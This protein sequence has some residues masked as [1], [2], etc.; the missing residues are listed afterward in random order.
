MRESEASLGDLT[1]WTSFIVMSE[2]VHVRAGDVAETSTRSCYRIVL[3]A[4]LV[5]LALQLPWISRPPFDAHP[6]RQAQTLATIELFA[7]EGIDIAHPKTNYVGEPGVFVLEL[8]LFQALCA[9]LY[10][11]FGQHVWLVRLVNLLFTLGNAG[12][13]FAIGKRLFNREAGF[14][15]MLIYLFAPL[16]LL[17]MTSTLID[18]S[19]TFCSLSAFLLALRILHA[20]SERRAGLVVWIGFALACAVTALIK[21]LYLFPTCVL[22][23]A[24]FL[25]RRKLSVS[26]LA[27]GLC[28]ILAAALFF[29][30]LRHSRHVND[31]SYFTKDINPTTLLGFE[32][33]GSFAFYKSMIRRFVLHVVGPGAAL[34]AVAGMIA[35]LRRGSTESSRFFPMAVLV[36]SIV[37][38]YLFFP[39]ANVPHDYYSLIVSPYGCLIAGFGALE[40][41]RRAGTS[42]IRWLAP[43]AKPPLVALTATAL[44]VAVFFKPTIVGGKPRLAP[45][46]SLQELEQLSQGRFDRWSFGMVF[47]A[48]DVGLPP[49]EIPF[50][51]PQILYAT[52]LRGSGYVVRDAQAALSVWNEKRPHYN[53]LKY[54]VFY[55]LNPPQ[56]IVQAARETIVADH[57]RKW[58]AYRLE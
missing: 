15:S 51:S 28:M 47:T 43:F 4:L 41:A 25:K 35:G 37:G 36:T 1:F 19:G 10:Q 16:T 33:L 23:A 29:L 58:F 21:T 26:L 56:E 50:E 31:A 30:W 22:L 42:R 27:T 45:A 48:P 7:V 14:V 24:T 44:S 2:F 53:H 39:K 46:P 6:F 54:A 34:L 5:V 3:I 38:Y 18:L 17:Y 8:P 57:D 52:G 20:E 13:I 11:W 55:R 32:P 12:L 9:L 49:P 40:L